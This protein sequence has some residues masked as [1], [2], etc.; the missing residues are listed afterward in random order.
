MEGSRS[1]PAEAQQATTDRE[2][3]MCRFNKFNMYEEMTVS[4][5]RVLFQL[6]QFLMSLVQPSRNGPLKT[7]VKRRYQLMI[8]DA[9]H[10]SSDNFVNR[11]PKCSRFDSD[12]E[13]EEDDNDFIIPDM[14]SFY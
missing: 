3:R 6:I 14:V 2:Q 5:S 4:L 13:L 1:S 8:N 10:N 7:G 11:G 9:A 12:N